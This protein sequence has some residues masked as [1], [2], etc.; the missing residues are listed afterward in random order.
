MGEYPIN[1]AH[2]P[3][4]SQWLSIAL[5]GKGRRKREWHVYRN[6]CELQENGITRGRAEEWRILLERLGTKADLAAAGQTGIQGY[7]VSRRQP[8][9]GLVPPAC[10]L[11]P[12]VS[13]KVSAA[14]DKSL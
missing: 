10:C 8:R 13:E 11:V 1:A 3:G 7:F 9:G 12:W 5:K 2:G 6:I 14:R 4:I